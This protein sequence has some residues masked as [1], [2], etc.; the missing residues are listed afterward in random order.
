MSLPWFLWQTV[1]RPGHASSHYDEWWVSIIPVWKQP[2]L[3]WLGMANEGCIIHPLTFLHL[4][5]LCCFPILSHIASLLSSFASV[6]C[7][8]CQPV[9][10]TPRPHAERRC[11]VFF[12]ICDW[13]LQ[14]QPWHRVGPKWV[15]GASHS[16]TTHEKTLGQIRAKPPVAVWT[17]RIV[18]LLFCAVKNGLTGTRCLWEGWDGLRWLKTSCDVVP[19]YH[20]WAVYAHNTLSKSFN[21]EHLKILMMFDSKSVK[22]IQHTLQ[23]SIMFCIVV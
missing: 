12:R 23:F 14:E 11:M 3:F 22:R 8:C 6:H 4:L 17:S 1:A 13:M 16:F 9:P 20:E 15:C 18:L 5:S 7:G 2:L 19:V 10:A 21:T